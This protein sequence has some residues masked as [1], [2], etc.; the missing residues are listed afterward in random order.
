MS[1]IEKQGVS[2]PRSVVSELGEPRWAVISFERCEKAGL[3]YQQ[4]RHELDRLEDHGIAGL[5]LVTD[6]AARRLQ[7]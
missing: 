3:T 6:E 7:D 2:S 5:C 1:T 4:A